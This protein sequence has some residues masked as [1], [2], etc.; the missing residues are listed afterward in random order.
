MNLILQALHNIPSAQVEHL[1]SVANAARIEQVAAHLYRLRA[2]NPQA[3]I[4]AYCFE[5]QIDYGF[6]PQGKQLADF[7]LLVMDMDSTLINIECIDEIADMQGIKPQVAEITESAMRG[8][9]DFAESLRRRVALLK[10]LDEAALLRVYD[11]RLK[12]N[13]GAETML[14]ELKKHGVM[15]LLVSG[16]FVFFTE[17]LKARLGLDFA[18]ANEL[19][20]VDGK[21][22]GNVSGKIVDAQGKADWLNHVREEFGLQAAQ[23]IAMGDGAN[24]LKMMAQAGVS[25]AYHAKPVV[26]AQASYALNFVGLDGLVNLLGN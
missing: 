16:G 12:L 5:H 2:V 13:P 1:A 19:E 3:N 15:T 22:T 18:H 14:T 17:R 11:E 20:I 9:I 24:D 26:R 8:E 25:I 21:L 4:A 6:V 7:G 23:V 10:G